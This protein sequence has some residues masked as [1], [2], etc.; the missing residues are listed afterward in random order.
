M[1][2]Q[3][4]PC[5][6]VH[7]RRSDS[8]HAQPRSRRRRPVAAGPFPACRPAHASTRAR[9]G[10]ARRLTRLPAIRRTQFLH[11]YLVSELA[12]LPLGATLHPESRAN[13]PIVG[14]RRGESSTARAAHS[15][16]LRRARL[17]AV[18]VPER[19]RA[20]RLGAVRDQQAS[21]R[22]DRDGAAL[23]VQAW[24]HRSARLPKRLLGHR[25]AT[26]RA[27]G[28]LRRR[29]TRRAL[30]T[31]RVSRPPRRC[32]ARRTLPAAVAHRTIGARA[33]ARSGS[34]CRRRKHP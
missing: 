30:R 26:V 14:P 19:P 18:R 16:R 33:N 5:D 10:A 2:R 1:L 21:L 28:L 23:G 7:A 24:R 12:R 20:I 32:C 34:R 25:E 4:T 27:S 6:R 9:P 3:A 13:A 22:F 29:E 15:R 8:R 17:L 31:V 11:P